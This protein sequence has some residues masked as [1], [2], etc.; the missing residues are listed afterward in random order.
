M[1]TITADD[2]TENIGK[3]VKFTTLNKY[4]TR[5][6]EGQIEGLVKYDMAKNISDIVSFQAGVSKNI[7]VVSVPSLESS[8]YVIIK[9]VVNEIVQLQAYS[10]FWILFDDW[11]V[12]VDANDRSDVNIKLIQVTLEEVNNALLLLANGSDTIVTKIAAVVITS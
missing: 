3:T 7:D 4:E 11:T 8:S 10:I 12:V 2:V 5:L 6:V 1:I 9:T